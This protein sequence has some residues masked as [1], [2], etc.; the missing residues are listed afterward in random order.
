MTRKGKST[1]EIILALREPG[2]RLGQGETVGKICRRF[3]IYAQLSPTG[4]VT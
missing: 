4:V 3:G 2:V 1:D